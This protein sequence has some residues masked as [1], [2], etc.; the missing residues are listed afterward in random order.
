MNIETSKTI[1]IYVSA[2]NWSASIVTT[3]KNGS[4][5]TLLANSNSMHPKMYL[6]GWESYRDESTEQ[7]ARVT[8]NHIN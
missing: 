8:V 6:K 5:I 3:Y 7:G 1:A 4:K 2:V